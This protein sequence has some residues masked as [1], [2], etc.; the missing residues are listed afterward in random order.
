MPA[1]LVPLVE[2]AFGHGIGTVF[3]FAAPAALLA[4]LAV[5]FIREVPLRARAAA[6]QPVAGQPAAERA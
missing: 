5:L 1:P 2:D 6:E 3:L 4:F